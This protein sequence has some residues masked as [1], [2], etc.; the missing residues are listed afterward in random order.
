MFLIPTI[1]LLTPK[2]LTP[3]IPSEFD[4]L[5]KKSRNALVIRDIHLE[6]GETFEFKFAVKETDMFLFRYETYNYGMLLNVEIILS[7]VKYELLNTEYTLHEHFDFFINHTGIITCS[8]THTGNKW[9]DQSGYIDLFIIVY[10]Q[11]FPPT[12]FPELNP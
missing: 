6:M 12:E 2:V 4:N 1:I 3:N 8:L 11:Y 5:Y 7:D 10:D 9:E